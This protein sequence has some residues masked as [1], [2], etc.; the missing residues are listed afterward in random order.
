M[1]MM[2]CSNTFVA[3]ATLALLVCIAGPAAA[4][5][6]NTGPWYSSAGPN[7]PNGEP[8]ITLIMSDLEREHGVHLLVG[9]EHHGVHIKGDE[10]RIDGWTNG[11]PAYGKILDAD[12]IQLPNEVLRRFTAAGEWI[13]AKELRP[14]T[15]RVLGEHL[16][17]TQGPNE[18]RY[19]SYPPGTGTWSI[20]PQD[21]VNLG[22]ATTLRLSLKTAQ[23]TAHPGDDR[24]FVPVPDPEKNA[25][26]PAK[27]ETPN[28]ITFHGESI[29]G[30]IFSESY[31]E[32]FVQNNSSRTV[33][34]TVKVIRR[35]GGR[36][37]E[38]VREITLLP[39]QK[40]AV[41][42]DPWGFQV[43]VICQ[44]VAARFK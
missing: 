38:S 31:E 22:G 28:V 37:S 44:I 40:L 13:S 5:S 7:A 26:A 29:G 39:S 21:H 34:A 27:P 42:H 1:S 35:E 2:R 24:F 30:G 43:E 16:V 25:P 10:V 15:V 36:S 19:Y 6:P 4:V 8:L 3:A 9:K 41:A 33:I 23:F 17:V 18:V 14:V 12:T 32:V 20:H 11:Q